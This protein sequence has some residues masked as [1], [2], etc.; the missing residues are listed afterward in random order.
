M[1][2]EKRQNLLS[3]LAKEPYEENFCFQVVSNYIVFS[4]NFKGKSKNSYFPFSLGTIFVLLSNKDEMA[5]NSPLC[6]GNSKR[7]DSA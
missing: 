2:L 5:Y 6:P 4:G 3:C 1:L 7:R